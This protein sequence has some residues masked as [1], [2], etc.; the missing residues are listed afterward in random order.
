MTRLRLW[1]SLLTASVVALIAI[2]SVLDDRSESEWQRYE[3]WS[4]SVISISIA[5]SF[6]GA[7]SSMLAPEMAMKVEL[8][9]IIIV[10]GFW[11]AGLPSILNP[12]QNLAVSPEFAISNANLFFFSYASLIFSLLLLGSWFEQKNGEDSTP[13][14]LG[15]VL[16]TS[17]SLIVMSSSIKVLQEDD[18]RRDASPYCNRTRFGIFGGMA[19]GAMALIVVLLR[20]HVPMNCQAVVGFLLLI[21][22]AC[23]VS[24]ITFGSGPGTTLG[25]LYFA[26]WSSFFICINLTATAANEYIIENDIRIVSGKDGGA[27]KKKVEE[28]AAVVVEEE[29]K[30]TEKHDEEETTK[31]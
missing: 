7:L 25:S 1:I 12:D 18:C 3:G 21:L 26:T 29:G 31:K 27:E 16:L 15:W 28:T 22:W 8:P 23:G 10:L 5:F 9:F 19:S 14:A 6:F 17:T 20:K 2:L 11:C 4:V 30:A 13:T 24:Y